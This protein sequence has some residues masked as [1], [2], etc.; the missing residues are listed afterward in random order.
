MPSGI[1]GHRSS[2]FN[3]YGEPDQ[4]EARRLLKAADIDTPVKLDLTYTSDHYGDATAKEFAVLKKQLNDSGLFE[5]TTEGVE[6]DEYRDDAMAGE[7]QAY[8]FGWYPDFPDADNFIAPFFEKK[9]FLNS[10]YTSEEI[11]DE[12]IPQ[13]RRETDRADTE[14]NFATAQDIVAEDVPLLP[15]WQGKQYIAAR[16][17]ITGA[18]W[19]LNSSSVLQLWELG[20]GVSG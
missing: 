10:S 12:I 20:R 11:R 6:W 3:E 13:T 17:D 19:A 7:Y 5:V 18:E 9:N 16:D 14:R 8:G 2:F 15:L 4:A 1:P